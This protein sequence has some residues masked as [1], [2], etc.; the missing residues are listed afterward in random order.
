MPKKKPTVTDIMVACYADP[1]L[2]VQVSF[3]WGQEGPLKDFKGPDKWQ[4]AQLK[5]IGQK[6]RKEPLGTIREAIASGHG[7]GKSAL[8]AWIILWA[9]STR[10]NVS[11]VV[12]ANTKTQLETKTWRELAVWHKRLIWNKDWF[13]WTATKFMH[14]EHPETWFFAAIPNTEHNS[15]AF[16]GLHA[17][18]VMV[19]F[20]EASA[21]SDRIWEVTEGAMTT[22]RA[23]W[24]T[25]GNPTRNTGRF[26]ECFGARQHRW[27][28]AQIDSRDCMMTNKEELKNWEE[29]YGEDSDF[30]RVRV[31]GVFPRASDSQFIPSDIVRNAMKRTLPKSAYQHYPR[32]LGVDVARFGT[33]RSVIIRRQGPK[34]W[35]PRSFV[36]LD[37]MEFSGIILDEARQFHATTIFVDG[38]G[39]GGGV[40]DRLRQL[41]LEVTDVQFG[42]QA[43]DRRSYV[44]LRS[45]L[46]GSMKEWLEGEVDLP[47]YRP[48]EEELTSIQ[49]GLNAKLQIQLE[50]KQDMLRRGLASP[51]VADSLVTSFAE[52][53]STLWVPKARSVR[54][55]SSVGWT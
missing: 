19:L 31:R 28:T 51:D 42:R 24:F 52:F 9:M 26:R 36:G 3:P 41:G 43:K 7:V 12:T 33:N 17:T 1:A 44:N 46:W 25:Y 50:Q 48:L 2:F 55:V 15:E 27:T 8:T 6:I 4:A 47:D 20:D 14:A 38:T 10:P 54:P 18:H 22:P 34:V 35:E 37:L 32:S 21:I 53:S 5:R 49:Y 30:F 45:E 29:D 16:A 13:K 39:V 40:V 23:M 11:G